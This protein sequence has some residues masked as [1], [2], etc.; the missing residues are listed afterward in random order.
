MLTGPLP[1]TSNHMTNAANLHSDP[2]VAADLWRK[3]S[4]L[5]AWLALI[6]A[7]AGFAL[8][9]AT[10]LRP[11][12]VAAG[13]D[14]YY[15]VLQVANLRDHGHPYF[16][17]ATPAALYFLTG[18]SYLTGDPA[19]AIKAGALILSMLLCVG[20]FL[21]V[22][23]CTRS[24]WLGVVVGTL[25]LA[26]SLHFY[27]LTE[28][29][30]NLAAVGL[31]VWCAWCMLRA[32]RGRRIAWAGFSL[33]L[34][35]GA[36]L[37]HRS[38]LPL[39][40]LFAILLALRE[41]LFAAEPHGRRR[42]AA[43]LVVFALWLAP[44]AL[45][46]QKPF[47]LPAPLA[48]GLSVRPEWPL[49]YYA[50]PEEA[51][52]LVTSLATILL[53]FLQRRRFPTGSAD[54][55]LGAVALFSLIITLNPFLDREQGWLGFTERLRALSYIQVAILVPGV[56]WLLLRWRR[57]YAAYVA[58]VVAPLLMVSLNLPL[59]RGMQPA[60]LGRRQELIQALQ[61]VSWTLGPA[62]IIIAPHGDQFV[63][64]ATTGLASQQRPPRN[65]QY[66]KLY[67]LL[68]GVNEQAL[69]DGS[70][71][72]LRDQSGATILVEDD[73]FRR[74]WE[75]MTSLDRGRLLRENP[76]LAKSL[77]PGQGSTA[78]E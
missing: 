27:M 58:A 45:W 77:S 57:E 78:L 14:G 59:P 18:I 42:A 5:W 35:A 49:D 30:S 46:A 34:L 48:G 75:A 8:R 23:E 60:Y 17:A 33:L 16:P 20:I 7:L 40:A 32:L 52:L 29:V 41:H 47:S 43:L 73:V 28:F 67:W 26:S 76:H 64:T 66:E 22:S 69:R 10:L 12:P 44:A 71:V 13:I 72:L 62:P 61:K 50:L 19:S 1:A 38:A 6:A 15:Y 53:L 11:Y 25:P 4:A 39:A 3:P 36:A 74:C 51:A 24:K 54:R 55:L 37:S 68:N 56:I 2:S 9:E 31:L 21:L 65:H 70:S 63:V